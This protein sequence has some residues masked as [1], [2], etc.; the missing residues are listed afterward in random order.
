MVSFFLHS[1][2]RDSPSTTALQHALRAERVSTT[3]RSR[4]CACE[5]TNFLL[6]VFLTYASRLVLMTSRI[7]AL[8]LCQA[9]LGHL[10]VRTSAQAFSV[11]K[12]ERWYWRTEHGMW[13]VK[14]L[15]LTGGA[16][17]SIRWWYEFILVIREAGLELWYW[18]T[19]ND[20]SNTH[21]FARCAAGDK[22][23]PQKKACDTYT[24]PWRQI[25]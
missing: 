12:F 7:Q 9:R 24:L 19:E 22:G 6:S 25:K 21:A 4:D 10:L 16:W 3:G 8:R 2:R 17:Y 20:E 5:R 18:C 11:L 15:R 13:N 14:D 23:E 1:A